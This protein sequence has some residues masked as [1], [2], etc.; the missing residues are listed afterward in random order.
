MR[1]ASSLE[2]TDPDDGKDWRQE[3]KGKTEDEMVGWHHWLN[4]HKF[5]QTSGE[6]EGQGSLAC[7]SP[8]SCKELDM[9]SNWTTTTN[10]IYGY[11]EWSLAACDNMDGS[12]GFYIKWHKSDRERKVLQISHMWNP[13]S[14]CIF[15]NFKTTLIDAET[16]LVVIRGGERREKWEKRVKCFCRF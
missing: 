14:K 2:K 5:E 12:L 9:I 3:E 7:C 1:K 6:S 15:Q 11:K 4:G 8:W 13:K 10:I 16:R